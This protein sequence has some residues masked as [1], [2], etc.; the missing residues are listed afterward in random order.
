MTAMFVCL[1]MLVIPA[2][3]SITLTLDGTARQT[4]VRVLLPDGFKH[5]EVLA[6]HDVASHI[7]K[8]ETSPYLVFEWP[9]PLGP[10]PAVMTIVYTVE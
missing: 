8:V 2:K 4:H 3:R 1:P 7:E 6:P 5:A 9:A 10:K